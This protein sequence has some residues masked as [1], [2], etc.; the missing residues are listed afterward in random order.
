MSEDYSVPVEEA[1]QR[2]AVQEDYDCGNGPEPCVHTFADSAIGLL[3]A[4]WDLPSAE[5]FMREWGVQQAGPAASATNHGLVVV[6]EN[7]KR[8]IFFETRETPAD[9]SSRN[10]V[11]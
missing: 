3:G 8:T 9:P 11:S 7:G 2:L 1:M 4:H 10:E 6:A 5:A